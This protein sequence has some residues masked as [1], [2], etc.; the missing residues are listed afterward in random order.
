MIPENRVLKIYFYYCVCVSICHMCVSGCGDQKRESDALK[1]E[2]L[3]V[4]SSPIWVLETELC[5]SA[6]ATSCS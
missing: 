4:V 6:R 5:S 3:E 1:L 2:F